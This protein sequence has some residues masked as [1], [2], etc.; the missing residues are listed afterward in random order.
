[1]SPEVF[2]GADGACRVSGTSAREEGL[3]ILTSPRREASLFKL[4]RNFA[5]RPFSFDRGAALF[6][7]IGGDAGLLVD[8]GDTHRFER[9][10]GDR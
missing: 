9:I 2:A 8:N 5:F 4:G 6:A 1:M 7:R 10:V 3:R